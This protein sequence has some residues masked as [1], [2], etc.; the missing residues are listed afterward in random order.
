MGSQIL[1]AK[2]VHVLDRSRT[3]VVGVRAQR[4]FGMFAQQAIDLSELR[5]AGVQALQRDLDVAQS[6]G[7]HNQMGHRMAGREPV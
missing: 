2:R 5:L 6:R 7:A 1:A 4:E 3:H